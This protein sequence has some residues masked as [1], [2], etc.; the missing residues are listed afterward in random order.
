MSF[1]AV[2]PAAFRARRLKISLVFLHAE[3]TFS[4]W[5]T[6]G[7]RIIQAQ[8]AEELAQKPL[9]TYSLSSLKPGVDAILS[10]EVPPPYA[11]DEPERLTARLIDAAERFFFDMKSLL[12]A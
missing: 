10:Q 9:G 6:A 11:F 4:L 7:N 3:G 5:L 1:V 2:A 8:T 12:E